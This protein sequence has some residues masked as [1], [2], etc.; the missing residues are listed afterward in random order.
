MAAETYV[1][2]PS[3]PHPDVALLIITD[4]IGHKMIN[5][6]LIADQFAEN[7]YFTIMPD[8]FHGDPVPMNRSEGFDI[9]KWLQ[10]KAGGGEGEGHLPSRVDP[11]VKAA[12][13]W[14]KEEKGVKRVGSVGYCFGAKYVVRHAAKDGGIDV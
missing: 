1:A 12:L 14:L 2:T 4:V 6:Q 8:V 10:G 11:V 9:M 3:K 7:G 13:K 5:A